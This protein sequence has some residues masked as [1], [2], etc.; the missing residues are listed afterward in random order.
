MKIFRW[1]KV[2]TSEGQFI[3]D[4]KRFLYLFANRARLDKENFIR[5]EKKSTTKMGSKSSRTV[6]SNP[7]C[8]SEKLICFD[9]SEDRKVQLELEC[10]FEELIIF[11]EPP[12]CEE[13]FSVNNG[14]NH[15]LLVLCGISAKKIIRRVHSNSQISSIYVFDENR[16][17]EDQFYD[18]FSKVN[19]LWIRNWVKSIFGQYECFLFRTI[20]SKRNVNSIDNLA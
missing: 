12:L 11:E 19:F 6:P 13:F 8:E 1:N 5:R 14:K 2:R 15:F 17:K 7:I 3:V 20:I 9:D 4:K 18:E 16:R 10:L